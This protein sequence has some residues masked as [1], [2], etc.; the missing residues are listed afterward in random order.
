MQTKHKS[1]TTA[2]FALLTLI[3]IFFAPVVHSATIDW[4]GGADPDRNWTTG[5]NWVGDIAPADGDDVQFLSTGVGI[6]EVDANVKVGSLRVLSDGYTLQGNNQIA[7]DPSGRWGTLYDVYIGGKLTQIDSNLQL[8]GDVGFY[9]PNFTVASDRPIINGIISEDATP[10]SITFEADSR[11][12]TLSLRGENTYSGGTKVSN[13]TLEIGDNS[14]LGTG[15]WTLNADKTGNGNPTYVYVTKDIT[16]TNAVSLNG[17]MLFGRYAPIAGTLT[18]SGPI[19]IDSTGVKIEEYDYNVNYRLELMGTITDNGN[20]FTLTTP[21]NSEILLGRTNNISGTLIWQTGGS[22]QLHNPAS[23]GSAVLSLSNDQAWGTGTLRIEQYVDNRSGLIVSEE[24]HVTIGNNI[25][26][27]AIKTSIGVGGWGERSVTLT[28]EFSSVNGVNNLQ[29]NAGSTLAGTGNITADTRV[30]IYGTDS[31]LAPA[32]SGKMGSLS[33]NGKL[34][35]GNNATRFEVDLKDAVPATGYDQV[36]VNG[37]IELNSAQLILTVDD[38]VRL[39]DSDLTFIVVNGGA[40]PITGTFN[41]LSEGATISLGQVNGQA[42]TAQISYFGNAALGELTG[43]NDVVLY[44]FT[45]A[46]VPLQGTVLIIN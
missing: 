30:F 18:L 42:A 29:I 4:D 24:N 14:A 37:D 33:I 44:N 16:L 8:H 43:G 10:R 13:M 28:G 3:V 17:Y 11:Y 9:S 41:G 32:G 22:G 39:K 34:Q 15:T 26:L 25:V 21:Q 19:S 7:I 31:T 45:N 27:D 40:N 20:G 12:K 5:D 46:F 2:F 35:F 36:E 38:V 23:T 1:N 6:V